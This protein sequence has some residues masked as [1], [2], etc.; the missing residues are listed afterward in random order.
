MEQAEQG[1]LKLWNFNYIYLLCLSAVVAI[2]FNMTMPIISKYALHLGATL[3]F[4]GIIA[5]GYSIAA[6]LVRPFAGAAN[7]RLNKKYLLIGATFG[8][9]FFTLACF[10]VRSPVLL[11]FIRFVH[12][13]CFGVSGTTNLAFATQYV[14]KKRL[15]EGV[16]YLGMTQ[17]LGSAVGPGISLSIADVWGLRAS[18]LVAFILVFV[19]ACCMLFIRYQKPVKATVDGKKVIHQRLHMADLFAL[20]VVPLAVFGGLLMMTNGLVSTYLVLLGDERGIANVGIYFTL[21]A[22]LL[23]LTR[24]MAGKISDRYGLTYVLL[25]AFLCGM[26][27]MYLLGNAQSLPMVLLVSVLQAFGASM[28][29]PALQAESIRLL[30]QEHSGV[31]TS[32]YYIGADLGI[33]GGPMLGG[34]IASHWGYTVMYHLAAVSMLVGLLGFL[35]YL[36]LRKSARRA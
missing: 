14:P 5:G 24:P 31:A 27:A 2:A 6:M 22:V 25:P 35:W 19:A 36:K 18:F 29:H 1:E 4:A 11:F 9:A 23:L 10:L 20:P 16:G 33:G 13:M 21:N 7:D 15:G 8:I 12:G 3:S 28:G 34:I 30:G 32:T 17:V 26:L